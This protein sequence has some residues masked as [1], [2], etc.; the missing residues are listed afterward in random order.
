MLPCMNLD[1]LVPII[2]E[3]GVQELKDVVYK[4]PDNPT[5]LLKILVALQL[6]RADPASSSSS[7]ES[8]SSSSMSSSS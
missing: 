3:E 1:C 7:E 5:D 4:L 6:E 2:G 8:S